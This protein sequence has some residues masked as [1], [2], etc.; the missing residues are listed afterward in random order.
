MEVGGTSAGLA[1]PL[2]DGDLVRVFSIVPLYEKTVTLRGNMANQGRFAWHPGMRISE[3]IPGQRVADHAQLLV[4]ASPVG[5]A[6]SGVRAPRESSHI[7]AA[8]AKICRRGNYL[9]ARAQWFA[10]S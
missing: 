4:E 8:P 10:A 7:F 5:T 2:A 9:A 1:T 6:G 3:L